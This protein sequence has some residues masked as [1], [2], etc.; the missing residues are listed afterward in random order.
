V[1]SLGAAV[2]ATTPASADTGPPQNNFVTAFLYS[3][4]DPTANPP[5]ANDWNCR[6]GSAHPV[7]V[8]LVHGTFENQYDNWAEISPVLK[9]AGYC[10]YALNYGGA[11]GSAIQGTGEIAASAGQ[12]ATFVSRVRTATGASKVDLVGHS[13]GGMMPR[14]YVRNLG[15]AST[16]DKLVALVPSNHGTTLDGLGALATEFPPV[17]GLVTTAC[18]ACTE[19]LAGS[20]F[21][22]ALNAGGETNPAVTY[23]V[24]STT[25]DEVVTPYTSAFL[26]AG[27]N[28]TNETVQSFCPIDLSE[29]VGIAYDPTAIRLVLNAL[30]PATARRATC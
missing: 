11:A 26:A 9:A 7:P 27:A 22:T 3:Q 1:L 4:V 8:V 2:L 19:Q 13:Q 30:D 28:V 20:S 14:Y 5:G 25:H 12:L 16:V 17:A 18:P 10:V 29:H 24:I 21:I 15:G 6:P 23:T